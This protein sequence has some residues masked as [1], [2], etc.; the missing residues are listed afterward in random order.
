MPR[1]QLHE[2]KHLCCAPVGL[3]DD[4]RCAG[5]VLAFLNNLQAHA[6]AVR[7]PGETAHRGGG[8]RLAALAGAGRRGARVLLGLGQLRAAGARPAAVSALRPLLAHLCQSVAWT[9]S[10]LLPRPVLHTMSA[11][12]AMRGPSDLADP[13]CSCLFAQQSI[14][15][16]VQPQKAHAALTL[17]ACIAL[18][19]F[20]NTAGHHHILITWLPD[21][22]AL[23]WSATAVI[24][25]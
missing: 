3:P 4:V 2:K 8:Q 13:C 7:D 10:T 23:G 25:A 22:A 16:V 1:T 20:I 19:A 18:S 12:I 5:L 9:R 24:V 21:F 11:G 15:E 17:Q 14:A 6:N